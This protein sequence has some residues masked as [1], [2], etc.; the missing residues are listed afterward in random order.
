[1]PQLLSV[2]GN[3]ASG[4]TTILEKLIVELKRRGHRIGVIKHA[5]HGFN[6]DQEGKDSWRHKNAGADTVLIASPGRI[7][8]I[9]DDEKSES[10]SYL[11]QYFNDVDLILIEGFKRKRWPKIEVFRAAV[12]EAPLFAGNSDLVA[13]VTDSNLDLNVPKFGLEEI[14]AL[15]DFIEMRYI[16]RVRN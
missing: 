6:L 10:L 16:K 3:S 13:W 12:H 15:A 1:M 14:P 4:K 8:I 11:K 5:H 2:V 9:K 7:A